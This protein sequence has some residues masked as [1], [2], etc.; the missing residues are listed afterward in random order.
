MSSEEVFACDK[1]MHETFE[2][3]MKDFIKPTFEAKST[4]NEVAK[5]LQTKDAQALFAANFDLLMVV[6][7]YYAC[8]DEPEGEK[9]EV[10][11]GGDVDG[12]VAVLPADEKKRKE[13]EAT[14]KKRLAQKAACARP[15]MN[16]GEL[17]APSAAKD[18]GL[19]LY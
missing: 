19:H 6:Y 8:Q 5:G 14:A 1:P 16:L 4:D 11:E 13:R 9:A 12:G 2:T 15:T 18:L 10:E 3:L 7:K 17:T